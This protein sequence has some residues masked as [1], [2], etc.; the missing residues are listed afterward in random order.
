[1]RW[2]AESGVFS[3]PLG[4]RILITNNIYSFLMNF[5]IGSDNHTYILLEVLSSQKAGCSHTSVLQFE[6]NHFLFSFQ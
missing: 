3:V 4:A 5:L 6:F 2:N 1:M